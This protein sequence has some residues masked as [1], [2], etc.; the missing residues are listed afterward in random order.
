MSSR[1]SLCPKN[2]TKLEVELLTNI[3]NNNVN[4]LVWEALLEWVFRKITPH[5]IAGALPLKV[6]KFLFSQHRT[7]LLMVLIW[8]IALVLPSCTDP[9]PPSCTKPE[10]CAFFALTGPMEACEEARCVGGQCRIV[11]K[12]SGTPCTSEPPCTTE[13]VCTAEGLCNTGRALSC[14]GDTVQDAQGPNWVDTSSSPSESVDSTPTNPDSSIRVSDGASPDDAGPENDGTEKDDPGPITFEGPVVISDTDHAINYPPVLLPSTDGKTVAYFSA[15]NEATG[16]AS[17]RAR[18]LDAQGDPLG[19]SEE[20]H[21]NEGG[22]L[23]TS[24]GSAS[25]NNTLS[26]FEQN[27]QSLRVWRVKD[28]L[29]VEERAVLDGVNLSLT[30]TLGNMG[31][32]WLAYTAGTGSRVEKI[33]NNGTRDL[34]YEGEGSSRIQIAHHENRI[35]ALTKVDIAPGD[36][37]MRLFEVGDPERPPLS[38]KFEGGGAG[39]SFGITL[40]GQGAQARI[41]A[42]WSHCGDQP[43][44]PLISADLDLQGFQVEGELHQ[45]CIGD[46]K[47]LPL[48][49]MGPNKLLTGWFE[50]DEL[51]LSTFET[52]SQQQNFYFESSLN[53]ALQQMFLSVAP[54]SSANENLILWP[55]MVT[56]LDTK[57]IYD[58]SVWKIQLFTN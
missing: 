21:F 9:P 55:G 45:S 39:R 37:E 52:P 12:A 15:M 38:L 22:P 50:S 31:K 46:A 47:N 20:I 10:D 35:Y 6:E 41:Y 19:A 7:S 49:P 28:F 18:L 48:I 53:P 44:A 54:T 25:M 24:S 27:S 5:I 57:K 43:T 33:L 26:L 13:G 32:I 14:S 29:K 56:S 51:L 8:G 2:K 4:H 23:L 30:N 16:P 58:V 40:L 42:A 17:I 36:S 11:P 34:M 3:E 1:S